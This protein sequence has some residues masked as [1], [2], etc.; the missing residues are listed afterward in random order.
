M[1]F[2]SAA[3]L[4]AHLAKPFAEDLFSLLVKYQ[5]ISASE[6]ASRLGLHIRTAQGFLEAMDS[7]G[8]V[9]KEEV[10]EKKRPY[11]RYTL[12]DPVIRLEIDLAEIRNEEFEGKLDRMIKERQ[13]ADARFAVA[14]GEY[15]IS[16]VTI[17]SGDGR[18]RSER[19]IS[20][21]LPQGR[22]LFHL[23]FPGA[24]HLAV[25]EIMER[26]G[27]D[28]DLWPEIL[29]IVDVLEEYGVIEAL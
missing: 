11:F 16:S 29:D 3:I 13:H 27:V 22:F 7:L 19:R 25:S 8:I 23:P 21:T 17:W 2:R 14:R 24:D 5:S 12:N 10:H 9:S 20:V 6:A 26:A 1:D 28:N 18:E 4:G 15:A